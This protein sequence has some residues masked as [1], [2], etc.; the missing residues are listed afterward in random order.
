MRRALMPDLTSRRQHSR[1][2]RKIHRGPKRVRTS[3]SRRVGFKASHVMKALSR[4][5]RPGIPA[6]RAAVALIFRGCAPPP[7]ASSLAVL[8]D[9]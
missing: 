4:R 5:S 9:P 3:H 1:N 8:T 7:I 2:S 6:H